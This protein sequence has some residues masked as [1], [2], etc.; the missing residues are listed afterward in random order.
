MV[1][2]INS[3]KNTAKLRKARKRQLSKW[4]V[5]IAIITL[6]LVFLAFM[7]IPLFSSPKAV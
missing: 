4:V 7:I 1:K 5:R 6:V 3:K 2:K